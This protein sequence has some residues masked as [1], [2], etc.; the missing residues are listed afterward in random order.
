MSECV[1]E[2]ECESVVVCACVSVC[3][4]GSACEC[5]R[6]R[7]S[8]CVCARVYV[9]HRFQ[10]ALEAAAPNEGARRGCDQ[11]EHLHKGC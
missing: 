4:C 7:A 11:L 9:L 2:C 6:V 10:E 8:V 5:V 1:C 3:V